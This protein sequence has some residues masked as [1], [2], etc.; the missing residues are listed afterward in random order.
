MGS[1]CLRFSRSRE[2]DNGLVLVAYDNQQESGIIE[3][4]IMLRESGEVEMLL[5]NV[6]ENN[7][8]YTEVHVYDCLDHLLARNLQF[9]YGLRRDYSR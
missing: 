2:R 1:F 9:K 7:N 5:Q 3:Y 8:M 4:P 6:D